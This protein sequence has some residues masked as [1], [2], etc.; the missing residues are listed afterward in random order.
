[1]EFLDS[2][3]KGYVEKVH[4]ER[5]SIETLREMLLIFDPSDVSNQ[6][7]FEYSHIDVD[8]VRYD[9]KGNCRMEHHS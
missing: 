9:D 7:D 6:D 1:M 8:D 3:H 5:M 2:S 4:V